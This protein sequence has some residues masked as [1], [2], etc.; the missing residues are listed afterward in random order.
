M[1]QPRSAIALLLVVGILTTGWLPAAG[2]RRATVK[3]QGPR[4]VLGSGVDA[5]HCD[6]GK[7]QGGAAGAGD[8]A[9][10]G[11]QVTWRHLLSG[12][13]ASRLPP[14]SQCATS[15]RCLIRKSQQPARPTLLK[16]RKSSC[17]AYLV[18]S[19]K[20]GARRSGG[21]V[22]A[23]APHIPTSAME[24]MARPLAAAMQTFSGIAA[25][26]GGLGAG[27]LAGLSGTVRVWQ[28]GQE[29]PRA[30][31]C[32]CVRWR[33]SCRD[34]PLHPAAALTCRLR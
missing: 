2:A 6:N 4:P 29:P 34:A 32:T 15:A 7:P 27:I 28:G 33:A 11:Q 24:P 17:R 26:I 5:D 10:A 25:K 16:E 14:A 12:R 8:R 19:T 9:P 30:L 23:S 18:V 13:A 31:L 21:G 3:P 20:Q 1:R 22:R